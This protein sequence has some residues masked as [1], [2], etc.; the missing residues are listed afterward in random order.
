[1]DNIHDLAKAG[2]VNHLI[3]LL[4]CGVD[5]NAQDKSLHMTPLHWAAG[6]GHVAACKLLIGRGAHVGS[7]DYFDMTPLHQAA[8]HGHGEVAELL[9]SLGADV[10][11][12]AEVGNTPLH[13]AAGENQ[14][15]LVEILLRRGASIEAIDTNGNTPLY[16]A[17][18]KGH[19][20]ACEFLLK[21]GADLNSKNYFGNTALDGA[22]EQG[23]SEICMLLT[24][25]GEQKTLRARKSLRVSDTLPAAS[26]DYLK[27]AGGAL[28]ISILLCVFGGVKFNEPV[29]LVGG[30][31]FLL[32]IFAFYTFLKAMGVEPFGYWHV[33]CPSCGH[34]FT[35][36]AA[37]DPEI[38]PTLTCPKC[39]K[40]FRWY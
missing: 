17:A 31:A 21:W 16:W 2:D 22:Q 10:N 23:H 29:S 20:E 35:T 40:V 15:H 6:Q 24:N 19:K 7:R 28:I 11:A 30:V 4:D 34:R 26:R 39:K 32:A 12:K 9:I 8:K 3:E 36:G 18:V 37:R 25:K 33:K 5:V 38:N 14:T 1:M 27:I 13:T